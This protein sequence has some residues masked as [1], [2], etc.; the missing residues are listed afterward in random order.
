MNSRPFFK[1]AG[2]SILCLV[3]LLAAAAD[4]KFQHHYMDRDLPGSSWGQTAIADV[5][6]DGKPD[7]ITGRSRGDILWYRQETPGRW[8]RHKLG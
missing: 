3:P 1:S 8:T 4:L 2:V 5:D 6:R 7:Y